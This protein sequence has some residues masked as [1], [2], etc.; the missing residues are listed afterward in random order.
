MEKDFRRRSRRPT[1]TGARRDGLDALLQKLQPPPP[2][3]ALVD[4]I[5][6]IRAAGAQRRPAWR[7]LT[8]G[9]ANSVRPWAA[10]A[11]TAAAVVFAAYVTTEDQRAAPPFVPAIVSVPAVS[12]LASKFGTLH[13]A[14][15]SATD[16]DEAT[17]DDDSETAEAFAEVEISMI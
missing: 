8:S 9:A 16:S 5:Y 17:D 2:S 3:A 15:T 10:G 13:P 12:S 6:R 1:A 11:A 14:E 7:R 4:R